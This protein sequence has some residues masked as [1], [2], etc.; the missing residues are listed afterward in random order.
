MAIDRSGVAARPRES[1][2][3]GNRMHHWKWQQ[4][5]ELFPRRSTADLNFL[6]E[7]ARK[8]SPDRSVCHDHPPLKS[9]IQSG[10]GKQ[11]HIMRKQAEQ[12]IQR[13]QAQQRML[14]S[15]REEGDVALL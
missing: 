8:H 4:N 15:N 7:I 6:E 2:P 5:A 13:L 3:K 14:Q 1:S 9:S 10:V 11:Q 12:I